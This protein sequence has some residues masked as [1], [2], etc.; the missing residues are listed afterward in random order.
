MSKM[1]GK[2]RDTLETEKHHRVWETL[3]RLRDNWAT[4]RYLVD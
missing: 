2:L 3:E 4:E 1:L